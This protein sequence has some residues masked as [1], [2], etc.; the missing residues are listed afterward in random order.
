MTTLGEDF[1]KVLR[2]CQKA[3]RPD[4]ADA[5]TAAVLAVVCNRD[6]LRQLARLANVAKG[7]PAGGDF[8]ERYFGIPPRR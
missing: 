8:V 5:A 6:E 3:K 1:A 7:R 2:D 4:L